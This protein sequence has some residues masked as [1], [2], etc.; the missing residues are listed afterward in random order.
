MPSYVQVLER[1]VR[2]VDRILLKHTRDSPSPAPPSS[3]SLAAM[4]STENA[5]GNGG[6][7]SSSSSNNNNNGVSG[8]GSGGSECLSHDVQQLYLRVMTNMFRHRLFKTRTSQDITPAEFR[9]EQEGKMSSL[10]S[11]LVRRRCRCCCVCV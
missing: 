7:G 9:A 3:S 10:R 4:E 2:I 8:G 6:G 1:A 5:S 11:L